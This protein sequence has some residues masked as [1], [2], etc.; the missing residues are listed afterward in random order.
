ME[1]VN[2]TCLF[3]FD[4]MP[5]YE[6]Q[7]F[8]LIQKRLESSELVGQNKK[9]KWKRVLVPLQGPNDCAIWLMMAATKIVQDCVAN[10]KTGIPSTVSLLK[11]DAKLFGQLARAQ[12]CNS[13]RTNQF[14]FEN[15]TALRHMEINWE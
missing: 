12:I 1:T 3:F 8:P 6:K 14:S 9:T 5:N 13:I 4:S 11:M 10:K 15:M 2:E 7:A